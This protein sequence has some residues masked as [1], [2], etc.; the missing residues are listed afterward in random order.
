MY[1][2]LLIVNQY[3]RSLTV[4]IANAFVRSGKYEEIVIAAGNE[5]LPDFHLDN[6][7]KIQKIASLT[8]IIPKI[9]W[10]NEA[11]RPNQSGW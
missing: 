7:V 11:V 1:R 8:L 3:A 2:K 9:F 10:T 6:S 4:E 5:I